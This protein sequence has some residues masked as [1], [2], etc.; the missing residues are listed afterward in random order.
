MPAA[1][2]TSSAWWRGR[3]EGREAPAGLRRRYRGL[4]GL[5]ADRWRPQDAGAP[6][7][8]HARLLAGATRLA[9]PPL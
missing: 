3:C 7:F 1:S 2:A 4:L 6:A 8:Q 5:H 9:V